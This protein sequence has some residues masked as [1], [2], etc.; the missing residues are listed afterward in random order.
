M[1]IVVFNFSEKSLPANTL[2]VNIRWYP[3]DIQRF[4]LLKL[5][6]VCPYQ[7]D[8]VGDGAL[9]DVAGLGEVDISD[10]AALHFYFQGLLLPTPSVM[11]KSDCK[12]RNYIQGLK[13]KMPK[14]MTDKLTLKDK[15][16]L[17]LSITNSLKYCLMNDFK[18]MFSNQRFQ[19]KSVLNWLWLLSITNN[20]ISPNWVSKKPRNWIKLP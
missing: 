13:K 18:A 14:I 7:F 1:L 20:K 11:E 17:L 12:H 3:L 9:E 16:T 4:K 5:A 10:V 6:A 2:N 19:W 8:F 15:K